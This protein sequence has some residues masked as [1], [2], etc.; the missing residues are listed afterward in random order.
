MAVRTSSCIQSDKNDIFHLRLQRYNFSRN[1][2][3]Y[4]TE[5][6]KNEIH[7]LTHDNFHLQETWEPRVEILKSHVV[8]FLRKA[9]KLYLCLWEQN[10]HT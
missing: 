6:C 9:E 2:A 1:K 8:L 4:L 5:K 7:Y 3:D 10:N